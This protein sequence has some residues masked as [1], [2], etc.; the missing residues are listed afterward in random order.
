MP[1]S[2]ICIQIEIKHDSKGEHQ[3]PYACSG[4]NGTVAQLIVNLKILLST[5]LS[6]KFQQKIKSTI[7]RDEL[8]FTFSNF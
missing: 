5:S 2:I 6:N 4:V 8:I 1:P 3:M 7:N